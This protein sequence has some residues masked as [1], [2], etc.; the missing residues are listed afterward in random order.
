[1]MASIPGEESQDIID[2]ARWRTH[3][4][5]TRQR[6]ERDYGHGQKR[7]ERLRGRLLVG[8]SIDL[9]SWVGRNVSG[10]GN[11]D[12]KGWIWVDDFFMQQ[13]LTSLLLWL[14]GRCICFDRLACLLGLLSSPCIFRCRS[15]P[16]HR[17]S[18]YPFL[19]FPSFLLI[20]V[21]LELKDNDQPEFNIFIAT[22]YY[23]KNFVTLI[24]LK[25]SKDILHV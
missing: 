9:W 17:L 1:M 2:K 25:C 18:F 5:D 22:C 15:F 19:S 10:L 16:F 24:N 7:V 4:I 20:L 14:V 8:C 3:F 11:L 21:K 13:R 6:L 12:G 23:V